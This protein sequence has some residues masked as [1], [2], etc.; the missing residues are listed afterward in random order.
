MKTSRLV[1]PTFFCLAFFASASGQNITVKKTPGNAYTV[2]AAGKA[3]TSFVFPD[4]LEKP[5]LYPIYAPDGQLVTRGFPVAPRKNEQFDHPH[6]IG[7]WLNYEK[8]NGLDFWNNSFAIA[9]DKKPNYG[10]IR[11]T[12][13]TSAKSGTSGQLSYTSQWQDIKHTVLL[14]EKTGFVFSVKDGNYIID[15]TTTLTAAQDVA[16]PDIKD[17]M[18]G[19]RVTRELELPSNEER[20][21]KDDKGNITKIKASSDPAISG[22]YLSSEGIQGDSVWSTRGR[23]CL[24]YGKKGADSLSIAIID[25]PKNVGYP[26]YWH[27]R[28]YGL[29]AANPLGQKIFSKGKEMLDFKLKKGESVTFRYRIVIAAG[30]KHLQKQQVDAMADDFAAAKP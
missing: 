15:R 30:K 7:L 6:H 8:V 4:T 16:M 20:E 27:A 1:L 26:T 19:L 10:W 23:W 9:K 29:F 28:G 22:N 5:V 13:V 18:L 25:H 21:Y 3:F 17:G 2:T 11:N 14:N 24:L 12:K